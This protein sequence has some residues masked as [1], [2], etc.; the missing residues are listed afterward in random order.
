MVPA[1]CTRRIGALTD[2]FLCLFDSNGDVVARNNDWKNSQQ[3]AIQATRL[4]PKND[5][6]S[7]ILRTLPPDNYTAILSGRN[8]TTGIGLIEIYKL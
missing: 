4:A 7:A 8:N 1:I 5:L 6:E 3:A 2:P